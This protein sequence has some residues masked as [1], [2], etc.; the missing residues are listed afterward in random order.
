M[1]CL[2]LVVKKLNVLLF[3]GALSLSGG[4]ASLAEPV[5]NSSHLVQQV[6]AMVNGDVYIYLDVIPTFTIDG[7]SQTFCNTS[8]FRIKALELGADQMHSV[9]LAALMASKKV[10]VEIS[11]STGCTDWGTQLGSI[12]IKAN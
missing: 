2:K 6:R 10:R 12:F 8:V 3:I 4:G 9:A 1:K 7:V 5:S 11:T